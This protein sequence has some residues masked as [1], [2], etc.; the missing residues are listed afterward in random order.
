MYACWFEGLS[1]FVFVF[2][3]LFCLVFC[4]GRYVFFLIFVKEIC[5]S[6]CEVV[7]VVLT[8]GTVEKDVLG[9]L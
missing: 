8:E 5:R 1:R 9:V 4:C 7:V 6:M 3:F 2:V